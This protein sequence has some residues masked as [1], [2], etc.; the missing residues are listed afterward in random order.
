M[1]G[2]VAGAVMVA[3]GALLLRHYSWALRN[4]LVLLAFAAGSLLSLAFTEFLPEAYHADESVAGFFLII[5]FCAFFV[6]DIL[7]HPHF[8]E[9][10]GSGR[11]IPVHWILVGWWVHSFFDGVALGIAFLSSLSAGFLVLLA[12][13]VHKFLDGI[14]ASSLLMSPSAPPGKINQ[15]LLFLSI[16]TPVGAVVSALVPLPDSSGVLA[17]RFAILAGLFIYLA[18]AD[19]LPQ[20]HDKREPKTVTAFFLGIAVFA[21]VRTL[22][23]E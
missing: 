15:Y 21:M 1:A 13:M 23:H 12:I 16:G 8:E 7:F 6:S 9:T 22:L 5:S 17:A 4:R 3:G 14:N 20:F 10:V 18:A 19:L 11:P 2:I